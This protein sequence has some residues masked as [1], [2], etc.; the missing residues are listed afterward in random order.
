MHDD[1]FTFVLAGGIFRAVPRLTAAVEPICR[2]SRRAAA[3]RRLDVEPAH[4]RGARLRWPSS[5]RTPVVPVSTLSVNLGDLP[6]TS[7]SWPRALAAPDRDASAPTAAARARP[8]DR[9]H[10]ASALRR[11]GRRCTPPA[12]PTSAGDDLQPRRIRRASPPDH[13][14]SYRGR[15]WSDTC[16]TTSTC[17][18]SASTSSTAG[19]A[20]RCRVRA[21]SRPRSCAPAASTC[22]SWASAPTATSASTSRRRRSS[23]RSH[24]VPLTPAI[25]PRQRRVASGIVWQRAARG[26]LDGHGDDSAARARS[27]R[28][29]RR[30]KAGGRADGRRTGDDAPARVVAAAA[31]RSKC[32]L[33]GAAA[34]KLDSTGAGSRRSSMNARPA[35]RSR[36]HGR[37]LTSR[38]TA[39]ATRRA[40]SRSRGS[41][42]SPMA[43]R[44]ELVGLPQPRE[45]LR[46]AE[47]ASSAS[48]SPP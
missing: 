45:R 29:D 10:A 2:R 48:R 41:M 38:S 36:V 1:A 25:A 43:S 30:R 21:V 40:A 15:T 4:G 16:S 18:R 33:D 42:S 7:V 20:I 8:A 6:Q 32:C 28:R 17:R 13:P 47:A 12:R 24:R 19:R 26:A 23:P 14:G 37:R 27:S 35:E 11:A 3:V 31:P 22:R 46:V 34:S 39:S 44:I 5:R 9:A